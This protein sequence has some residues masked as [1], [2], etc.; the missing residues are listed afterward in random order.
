MDHRVLVKGLSLS[1]KLIGGFTSWGVVWDRI[2][3]VFRKALFTVG[4]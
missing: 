1:S 3:D 2:Y 4:H